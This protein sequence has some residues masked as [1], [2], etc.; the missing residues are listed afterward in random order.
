MIR[1]GTKVLQA[2]VKGEWKYVFCRALNSSNHPIPGLV[3]TS[4]YKKALPG[5]DKEYFERHF[6]LTAFRV[7]NA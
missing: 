5:I 4:D 3:T 1:R 6:G 7:V 2:N